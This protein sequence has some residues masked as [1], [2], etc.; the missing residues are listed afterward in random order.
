MIARRAILVIALIALA[1]FALLPKAA[2]ADPTSVYRGG[3]YW[4]SVVV[5]PGQVVAG[6]LTVFMGNATIEGTVKG[7]VN[8]VGGN[9]YLRGGTVEGQNHAVLGSVVES[10]APW[11][12]TDDGYGTVPSDKHLWWRI[13]SDVVALVVFLIFPLRSR[14]ALDRLEQH[15]G[16][17]TLAGLCGWV[18]VLPVAVLLFFTFVLIPLIPIEMVLLVVALFCR[19][20]LAR[21][22]GRTPFLRTAAAALDPRAALCADLWAR[23]PHRS[24]TGAGAG[25]RG[26]HPDHAGRPGCRAADLRPRLGAAGARARRAAAADPAGDRRTAYARRLIFLDAMKTHISRGAKFAQRT[27]RL[28]ASTIR[29]MLKVTQQPD[30]ISFGGGLPAP[31]LFPTREIAEVTAEV[32]END[33][34]AALQYGVTAGIPE[35][36]G[37]VAQRLT[38]R[39]EF[40]VDASEILIVNG[41]QQGLDLIGKIFIDP[42]DHVVMENPSYLGAI[43]AFDAYQA[44]YLSVETDEDGMIP[45]SLERL[46]EHAD[47]FPKFLYAVPNFQN[48]TGRTLS[49]E[50]REAIVRICERFDLPIVED[51]PYGELRFEGEHLPRSLRSRTS[52]TVIYSGTGSKIMAPGLRVAWLAIRDHDVR[53]KIEL[54]KQGT[55]LQTGSLAQY[56]FHGL[57]LAS[58][59]VRSAR[60]SQIVTTYSRRRDVMV[61]ALR[62]HMPASVHFNNPSGGMFLWVTIDGVD[63]SELFK[64]SAQQKVVFVPGVSF[65]PQRD[66]T[67]GMRLNFSNA[68]EENI[69]EGIR[70][71]SGAVRAFTA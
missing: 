16:T 30:I 61:E 58:R 29:E 24:R 33:G 62:E 25:D 41:S 8:V 57:R 3:T 55:D 37:W 20:S 26:H 15:P 39:L 28:R 45:H 6:D 34:A 19:Q 59:S 52:A 40:P 23:A 68:S 27:N 67:D 69:R 12:Q 70:R 10:I 9:V 48:P 21:S 66:V 36:R 31:E 54:A 53:E 44:R 65:Y 17:A 43:Q 71:L 14:M 50:R 63:T 35:L 22:A 18:A 49:G 4:G 7:D 38:R 1:A 51:D 46:L 56:V 5:E 64:L 13:A 2:L 11:A 42:G 32:M 47:P 60:G